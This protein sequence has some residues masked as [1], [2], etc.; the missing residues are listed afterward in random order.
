MWFDRLEPE[1]ALTRS[2]VKA[3]DWTTWTITNTGTVGPNAPRITPCLDPSKSPYF[4]PRA[5]KRAAWPVRQSGRRSPVSLC[6]IAL[7]WQKTGLL[8]LPDLFLAGI[9][10]QS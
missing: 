6:R 9:T 7:S 3:S 2:K 1:D 8:V 4:T 10:R 5:K